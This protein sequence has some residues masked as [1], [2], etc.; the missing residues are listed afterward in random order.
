[1]R[2]AVVVSRKVFDIIGLRVYSRGLPWAA[3]EGRLSSIVLHGERFP[4]VIR[5]K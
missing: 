4:G 1:M 2:F 5:E 3:R